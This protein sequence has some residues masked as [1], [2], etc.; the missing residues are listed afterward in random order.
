MARD[1]GGLRD[2]GDHAVSV[3]SV[4][5]LAGDRSQHQRPGVALAPTGLQHS[6]HRDGQRHRGGLVALADQMQ[7]PVAPQRLGVVVDPNRRRL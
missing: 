3:A 6:E 5:R 7:N 1:P 2:A 4:D